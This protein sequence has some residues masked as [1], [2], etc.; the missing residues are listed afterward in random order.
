[1]GGTRHTW[2]P[3]LHTRGHPVLWALDY[4][5]EDDLL[6][7]SEPYS[8]TIQPATW[9]V[10]ETHSGSGTVE[11]SITHE[12]NHGLGEVMNALIGAGLQ[13]DLVEEHRFLEWEVSLGMVH[14]KGRYE[15]PPGRRDHV[16]L[17]YSISA[18]RSTDVGSR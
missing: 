16:P 6:V 9:D 11:N 5:R 3:V 4:E 13:I 2:R 10:P 8:E 18:T 1:M 14:R 17:M 12:W 7:T 15:M